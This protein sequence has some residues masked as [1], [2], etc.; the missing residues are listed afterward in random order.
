MPPGMAGSD[1]PAS[2]TGDLTGVTI[3]VD[4]V[5]HLGHDGSDPLVACGS[6]ERWPPWRRPEPPWWRSPSRCSTS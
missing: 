6:M 5:N 2:L 1:Y 3:G 4:R